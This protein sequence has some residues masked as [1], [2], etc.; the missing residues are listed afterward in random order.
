MK[1]ITIKTLAIG[2]VATTMLMFTSCKKTHTCTCST[3]S[4]STQP[5]YTAQPA[6]SDVISYTSKSTK[7]A[8]NL[9]CQPGTNTDTQTI[10]ADSTGTV[11]GVNFGQHY[12][13]TY[14]NTNTK[15]CTIK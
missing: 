13:Y 12:T 11:F 8:A 1:T 7:E 4:T 15:T 3:T 6:S 5:G 14:T 2:I 10:T 9:N